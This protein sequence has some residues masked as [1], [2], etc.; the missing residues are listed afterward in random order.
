MGHGWA[1]ANIHIGDERW[2]GAGPARLEAARAAG[3]RVWLDNAT[4][5]GQWEAG[6]ARGGHG[7]V[8]FL[9]I[10]PWWVDQ[11]AADDLTRLA[12][13]AEAL[14]V[15][16][17]EIGLDQW[18]TPRDE[19]RQERYFL[20]QCDLALALDRPMT[21]HC[22]RAWAWLERLLATR[23]HWPR[24]LLHAYSGPPEMIAP[25]VAVGAYFSIGGAA[26]EPCKA[27][28][29]PIMQQIPEDRLLVETDAP[30]MP[31]PP[32]WGPHNTD[33]LN[34]PA[35]LPSIAQGL[36]QLLNRDPDQFQAQT[37]ANTRAFV[38]AELWEAWTHD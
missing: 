25:L 22:L 32:V 9:G 27:N 29:I 5:A 28:R 37:W 2:Q 4:D 15:G 6:L 31:P 1:D 24:L 21:V 11:S 16:I 13:L 20:A 3:V 19:A 33:N 14:P 7:V 34:P 23:P 18:I 35:N 26:L 30:Y 10:H 17:G 12:R 8:P 38:G 36:A